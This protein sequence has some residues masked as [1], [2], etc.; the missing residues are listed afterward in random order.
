MF[1][2]YRR[3]PQVV[4]RRLLKKEKVSGQKI[5]HT[6]W[7][8]LVVVFLVLA[9]YDHRFGWSSQVLAPIPWWLT[10]AALLLILAGDAWIFQVLQANRFAASVI[11]V[12]AKQTV[13]DTGPYRWVR[14]PMYFGSLLIWLGSPLALGSFVAVPVS[15]LILPTLVFRLRSEEAVLR[16]E[17]PG[18]VEY[19]DRTRYRLIPFVW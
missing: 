12:E 8:M 18:Y 11:Q 13:I 5:I 10:V 16:R 17:L 7:K 9:G 14:H 19:C 6:A 4:E 1:Y 15:F 2:F 3:D